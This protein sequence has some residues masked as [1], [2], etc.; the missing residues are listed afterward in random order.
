MIVAFRVDASREI[1]GGHVMRCL[2][3]ADA[4][5]AA[6]ARCLFLCRA[7]IGDMIGAI[8]ARGFAVAR[9]PAPTA[10]YRGGPDDPPHA[11]WAGASWRVDADDCTAALAGLDLDGAALDWLVVD[12]YA[13]DARWSEAMRAA[14]RRVMVIDDLDDRPIDADLLLDQSRLPALGPR[15]HLA[16]RTL[17]GP[18]YALLRPAFRERRAVSLA[19]RRRP[20]T[21]PRLLIST[22]LL[23]IGGGALF[24]AE[25]LAEA[26]V[27]IDVAVGAHATSAGALGALCERAPGLTLHLDAGNMAELMAEADLAIGAAGATTWE[28]LC[29]GLPALLFVL[30]DNQRPIA[31]GLAAEGLATVIGAPGDLGAKALCDAVTR[32]LADP[33]ALR[34]EAET[35]ARVCDGLGAERAT[36][37]ILERR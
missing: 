7:H 27:A 37:E 25:A 14:A 19:R 15:R 21:R 12:H 4:L 34:A 30:A 28:R 24:A 8:E 20:A 23:D 9:L 35:I 22:G 31:E 13:L 16:T 6:G 2:A 3:L 33:E 18:R 32:K 36:S 17:I 26:G 11:S 10:P 1:G 29:L 5:T